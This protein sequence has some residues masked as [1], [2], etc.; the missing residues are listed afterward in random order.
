MRGAGKLRVVLRPTESGRLRPQK[1]AHVFVG[2]A[3]LVAAG[4]RRAVRR[5]VAG[6]LSPRQ[7][8]RFLAS[9]LEGDG[10]DRACAAA[11]LSLAEALLERMRDR[12]F[13]AAWVAA[14]GERLEAAESLLIDQLVSGARKAG[15]EGPPDKALTAL[16]QSLREERRRP[17]PPRA[18]A[19]LERPATAA[20]PAVAAAEARAA[21]ADAAA[22]AD[23][24]LADTVA[25]VAAAMAEAEAELGIAPDGTP[26]G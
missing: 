22:R 7:R 13:R 2:V 23:A 24:L 4:R 20:A 12:R 5:G 9:L 11:G 18:E 15:R 17:A 8:Q 19:E 10:V 16:W 26:R 14:D 25:R 21:A 3:R 1:G 6:R